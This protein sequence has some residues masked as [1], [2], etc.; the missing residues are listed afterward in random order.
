MEEEEG[1]I[2]VYKH[3]WVEVP[4]EDDLVLVRESEAPTK[5]YNPMVENPVLFTTFAGLGP[6]KSRDD[7][8][9]YR[10]T[11]ARM[12]GPILAF[13]EKYG[14]VGRAG[15]DE[16]AT[17]GTPF[18]TWKYCI[19]II[20]QLT[21]AWRRNDF[22]TQHQEFIRL[23]MPLDPVQ[24]FLPSCTSKKSGCKTSSTTWSKDFTLH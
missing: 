14:D 23:Y 17:R 8:R 4:E 19:A 5:V 12:A 9:N 3:R 1:G 21:D 24:C 13:A 2:A 11:R 16:S 18:T 7:K 10:E 6:P 15:F 22:D 20:H